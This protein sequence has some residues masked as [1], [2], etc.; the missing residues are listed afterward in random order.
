MSK[1]TSVTSD[2]G[3]VV[4]TCVAYDID[5]YGCTVFGDN[6][7]LGQTD[8][9]L[10]SPDLLEH[11][12]RDTAI[13]WTKSHPLVEERPP[14]VTVESDGQQ[15]PWVEMARNARVTARMS[16]RECRDAIRERSGVR[17]SIVELSAWE[18]GEIGLPEQR[19]VDAWADVLG[20]SGPVPPAI[21]QEARS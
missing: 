14:L 20:I 6:R 3:R 21:T 11:V 7:Y 1:R 17:I 8:G 19:I 13:W 9:M 18:R 5:R 10:F 2:D 12:A 4:V 15:I 16:L